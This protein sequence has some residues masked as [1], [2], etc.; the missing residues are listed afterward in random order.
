MK[1]S[2]RRGKEALDKLNGWKRLWVLL[3][4]LWLWPVLAVTISKLPSR[5]T[6]KVLHDW[7]SEKIDLV[8]QY[9]PTNESLAEFR[10]RVYGARTD[11]EIV[12]PKSEP[13]KFDASSAVPAETDDAIDQKYRTLF[14]RLSNESEGKAIGVGFLLWIIP[15]II[16]YLIAIAAKWVYLGFHAAEVQK[17]PS[18]QFTLIKPEHTFKKLV[19]RSTLSLSEAMDQV[20]TWSITGLAAIIGLFISK[21]DTVG[22]LVSRGGLR[23]SLILFTISLVVGALSKQFGIAI[24]KGIAMVQKLE[25][26]LFSE[27][28]QALMRQ[29]TMSPQQLIEEISSPFF[30]PLSSF[31]RKSGLKGLKDPLSGD[32][33]F[34]MLFGIHLILVQLHVLFAAAGFIVIALSIVP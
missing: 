22:H 15:P 10:L 13:G 17:S 19:W 1:W 6:I 3:V 8:R 28:G 5:E 33:R 29:M 23:W 32:K 11:E 25:G 21:I 18:D 34:V 16:I 7:A 20:T 4:V 26:L 27:Q 9:H 24:V 12:H 2:F 30:W 31:M 14:E